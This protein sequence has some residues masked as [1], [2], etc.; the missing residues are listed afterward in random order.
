LRAKKRPPHPWGITS[1]LA[2]D[3]HAEPGLAWIRVEL[4]ESN[5]SQ[6]KLEISMN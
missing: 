2:G 5:F 4:T 3:T 1:E 6:L